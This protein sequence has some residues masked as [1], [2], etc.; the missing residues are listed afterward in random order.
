MKKKKKKKLS[1]C[2]PVIEHGHRP[3]RIGRYKLTEKSNKNLG[4]S[5]VREIFVR[6]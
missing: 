2:V 3:N 6:G 1:V 4:L 5:I